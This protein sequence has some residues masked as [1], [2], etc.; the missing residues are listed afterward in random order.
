MK[1][2]IP[3][4]LL[5]S[6]AYGQCVPVPMPIDA[7]SGLDGAVYS[8]VVFDDGTG[9]ALYLGGSFTM[10]GNIRAVSIVKWNGQECVALGTG[11]TRS[12]QCMAV[13]GNSLLV[14]GGS[15][16]GV[17]WRWQNGAWTT[18]GPSFPTGSEIRAIRVTTD[19][20]YVGG[21]TM[22]PTS[23]LAALRNDVW[24]AVGGGVTGEVYALEQVGTRWIVGGNLTHAGGAT[25]IDVNSIAQWD[26][27][28]WSA[29][30]AGL[31]G[32]VRTIT[33]LNNEIYAGGS[34]EAS[35]G[36]AVTCVGKF[37]GTNWREVGNGLEGPVYQLS[38]IDGSLVA[39]GAF[40][41]S[42]GTQLDRVA[43]L[44]NG[45]WEPVASGIN[46]D[47]RT[48]AQFA[49]KLY[50]GGDFTRAEGKPA[51]RV[52]SLNNGHWRGLLSGID[53]TVSALT[54][55]QDRL[56]VS[57][58]F[59]QV[60][61][62]SAR[63]MASF[64]G[65]SWAQFGADAGFSANCFT[66]F[67]GQLLA[68][69]VFSVPGGPSGVARFNGSTWDA[70]GALEGNVRGMHVHNDVLYAYG[71]GL[72]RQAPGGQPYY[73]LAKWDGTNWVNGFPGVNRSVAV[74]ALESFNGRL[75]MAGDSA[76]TLVGVWDLSGVEPVPAAQSANSRYALK[77]FNGQLYIGGGQPVLAAWTGTSL[78]PVNTGA[79]SG[80][81]SI[82]EHFAVHAGR[83]YAIGWFT[84]P[85]NSATATTVIRIVDG[86][87]PTSVKT[88][89]SAAIG[90]YQPTTT[91]QS[92]GSRL[93]VGGSFKF[94]GASATSTNASAFL[95]SLMCQCAAD[96]NNDTVVDTFDYL[97][98]LQQFSANNV[99][100]DVNTD[101]AVDFFDY[102]DFVGAMSE[103]C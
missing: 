45:G 103:G 51:L 70:M 20:I 82:T 58:S 68:G 93:Y 3:I 7:Y 77:A 94:L 56:I 100:A 36:V 97:D 88:G 81:Q 25:G 86:Q 12:V 76:G 85:G 21:R 23:G 13:D 102:L 17:L 24:E 40:T 19:G 44:V 22:T 41:T 62:V 71:Y 6:A 99:T 50:A 67:E 48:V 11:P 18:V 98:F 55:F 59:S 47:V 83:L 27:T 53:G 1:R 89:V 90:S 37:D 15:I 66:E 32:T 54:K 78:V 9:P 10:A 95:S 8:S 42:N 64:D 73:G 101:G 49:G 69:G 46:G 33:L 60:G 35:G 65:D 79:M 39:A 29:M 96:F 26:G 80:S 72:L 4:L 28:Q 5:T 2:A 84:P 34:F 30:G 74:T 87:T 91:A 31:D 16:G 63:R 92:F 57:G 14:S 61:G 52:A 75:Y 43:R 38:N